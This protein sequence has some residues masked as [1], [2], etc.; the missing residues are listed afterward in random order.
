MKISLLLIVCNEEY[1]LP[2]CIASARPVV[3]EVVVLVQKSH[4]RTLELALELADVVV[5]RPCLGACEPSRPDGLAACSGDWVIDLHADELL[6]V[7]DPVAL[8][9]LL[10]E[11]SPRTGMYALRWRVWAGGGPLVD[12]PNNR[13]FRREAGVPG[14]VCHSPWEVAPGYS[15]KPLAEAWIDSH[16]TWAEQ[17]ADDARYARLF[18]HTRSK[19]YPSRPFFRNSMDEETWGHIS[20]EFN[21]Y[22]LPPDLTGFTVLDIGANIGSFAR[23]CLNR[24]AVFVL[25]V[26]PDREN[27]DILCHNMAPEGG[28]VVCV[29]AAAWRSDSGHEN[30]RLCPSDW[31]SAPGANPG[32]AFVMVSGDYEEVSAVS[33][34]R[35]VAMCGGGGEVDLVKID[36]EGSEWPILFTAK[37]LTKCRRVIGE[38]HDF[39]AGMFQETTPVEGAVY[40]ADALRGIL[41]GAGFA[42][43]VWVREGTGLGLFW[44]TQLGHSL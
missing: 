27:F 21:E 8:R 6:V 33:F 34:D 26:E 44:A 29:R 4:D 31:K 3:D 40:S 5:E 28:R 32:G 7:P 25:C 2:L 9:R 24:G 39:H 11:S 13:L 1:R 30:D 10:E 37:S 42:V 43:D 12:S 20:G 19:K 36:C 16:K 14:V 35:L 41:E 17:K 22:R 38:W 15:T 18:G 23:A